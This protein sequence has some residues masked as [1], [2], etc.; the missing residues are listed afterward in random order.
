MIG[1]FIVIESIISLNLKKN[2]SKT[3]LLLIDYFFIFSS[4]KIKDKLKQK[5]QIQISLLLLINCLYLFLKIIILF[6]ILFFILYI[7]NIKIEQ[8]LVIF[9]DFKVIIL[10]TLLS[11]LYIYIRCK[12][13][14][15]TLF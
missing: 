12:I 10:T 9:R 14:K 4:K 5:K 1:T 2:I 8:A 15:I 13:K 7:F 3:K 11:S 6:I